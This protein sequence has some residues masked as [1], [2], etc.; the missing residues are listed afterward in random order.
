MAMIWRRRTHSGRDDKPVEAGL[1]P[2]PMRASDRVAPPVELFEAVDR[3][4]MVLSARRD[5]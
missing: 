5:G 4:V 2:P 3:V 1:S